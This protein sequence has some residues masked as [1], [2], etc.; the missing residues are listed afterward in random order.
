[1]KAWLFLFVAVSLTVH[2]ASSLS[3]SGLGPSPSLAA[4]LTEEQQRVQEMERRRAAAAAHMEAQRVQRLVEQETARLKAAAI[5]EERRAQRELEAKK[6]EAL[7]QEADIARQVQ[8]ARRAAEQANTN[9]AVERLAAERAKR[10][11]DGAGEEL[12]TINERMDRLF[13]VRAQCVARQPA[14][15]EAIAMDRERQKRAAG[16][17]VIFASREDQL[18]AALL[19]KF[20][21][22]NGPISAAQMQFMDEG[23]RNAAR[24]VPGALPPELDELAGALAAIRRKLEETNISILELERKRIELEIAGV[25]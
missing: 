16:R 21:R 10:P 7:R 14:L 18:R 5:M 4:P 20:V 15:E 25:K 19:A 2:A 8:A 13:A 9:R 17:A 23:T 3:T 6:R 22:E 24:L 11:A 1:M 12:R